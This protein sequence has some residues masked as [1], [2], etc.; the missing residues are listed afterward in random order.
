[1][2]FHKARWMSALAFHESADPLARGDSSDGLFK[3]ARHDPESE[4]LDVGFQIL[5][6]GLGATRNSRLFHAWELG[7]SETPLLERPLVISTF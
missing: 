2:P 7:S 1:M 3:G 4:N 6:R 5:V